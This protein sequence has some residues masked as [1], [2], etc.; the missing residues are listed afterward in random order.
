MIVIIGLL[1]LISAAVV[2][3]FVIATNG[4][5]AHSVGDNFVLFGQ[6]LH[7]VSIGQLFLAGILVGVIAMLGMGM[8]MGAFGR[9]SASRGSRR[10]LDGS[11][12]ETAVFRADRDRLAQRLD[13]EHF[14]QLRVN[15][16][17][18]AADSNPLAVGTS[19]TANNQT[20]NNQAANNQAANTTMLRSSDISAEPVLPLREVSPNRQT[21]AP[22]EVHVGRM[23]AWQRMGRR[24]RTD[25]QTQ[26]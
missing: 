17:G 15:A 5:A 4:G 2:A 22:E 12:R 25:D 14:E 24:H 1:I 11:R 26:K 19:Q 10:E 18:S 8:L 7:G 21:T 9:Q 16:P 3:I 13:D 6:Q 23:A 20:T